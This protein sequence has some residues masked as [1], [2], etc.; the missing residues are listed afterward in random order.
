MLATIEDMDTLLNTLRLKTRTDEIKRQGCTTSIQQVFK[1]GILNVL[2]PNGTSTHHGKTRLH[3]EDHSATNH[4]QEAPEIG[5]SC[6]LG[7]L[8]CIADT[9]QNI[10]CC[11]TAIAAIL[12]GGA[13]HKDVARGL[14]RHGCCMLLIL[15]PN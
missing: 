3:K 6:V 9:L 5:F 10:S 14:V 7:V 11:I 8:V 12:H 2:Q 4:Q 1:H 15:F 13:L